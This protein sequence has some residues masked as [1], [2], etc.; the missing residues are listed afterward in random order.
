[1]R[2]DPYT[3]DFF[4]EHHPFDVSDAQYEAR[5]RPVGQPCPELTGERGRAYV[6]ERVEAFGNPLLL[7]ML[8][9]VRAIDKGDAEERSLER[10][11]ALKRIANMERKQAFKR[12][13]VALID[14]PEKGDPEGL[15]EPIVTEAAEK[16]IADVTPANFIPDL[17]VDLVELVKEHRPGPQGR[18]VPRLDHRDYVRA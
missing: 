13:V 9:E 14:Y 2:I 18:R 12:R 4:L 8:Q 10:R 1:M 6:R 5:E 16:I 15:L 11:L 7:A 3:V 17:A